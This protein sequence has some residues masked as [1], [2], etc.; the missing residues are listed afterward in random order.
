MLSN[1]PATDPKTRRRRSTHTPKRPE[2]LDVF[3]SE[4]ESAMLTGL[5][6]R[7]GLNRSDW[8]RLMLRRE[9]AKAGA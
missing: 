1:M 7:Q 8:F 5:A 3:L 6:K 2:R 4:E 9:H